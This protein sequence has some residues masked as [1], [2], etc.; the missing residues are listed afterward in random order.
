MDYSGRSLKAQMKQANRINSRFTLI[1]GDNELAAGEAPLR[2][3]T[4][5]EQQ[6]FTLAGE[7]AQQARDLAAFLNN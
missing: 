2:N 7:L 1:I 6:S 5:Q 3:M 4:T